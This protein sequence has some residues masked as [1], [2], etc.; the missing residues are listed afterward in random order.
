[1]ACI[2]LAGILSSCATTVQRESTGRCTIKSPPGH[3]VTITVDPDN[4]VTVNS[5]APNVIESA[6]GGLV[7][8]LAKAFSKPQP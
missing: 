7:G 6:V 4:T 8:G 5:R 2:A 1:M 3:S